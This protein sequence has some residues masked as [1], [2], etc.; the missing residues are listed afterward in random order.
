MSSFPQ[1]REFKNNAKAMLKADPA[2][3]SVV[4]GRYFPEIAR[5]IREAGGRGENSIVV[6]FEVADYADERECGKYISEAGQRIA[7]RGFVCSVNYDTY[8][9]ALD[10]AGGVK[11]SIL[12]NPKI[13]ALTIAW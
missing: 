6:K 2:V 1:A 5:L 8:S 4:L 3:D 10:G 12:R 7:A 11:N 13:I 9:L